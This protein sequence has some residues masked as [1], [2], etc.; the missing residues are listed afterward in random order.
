[1]VKIELTDEEILLLRSMQKHMDVIGYM[2]G[3][4]DTL[5]IYDLKNCQIVMDVDENGIVRHTSITKHFRK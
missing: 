4:L 1:M 5:N 3:Y 2:T